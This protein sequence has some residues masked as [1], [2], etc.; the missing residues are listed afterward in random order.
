MSKTFYEIVGNKSYRQLTQ[1]E[2]E[3]VQDRQ[4]ELVI[5]WQDER[6]ELRKAEIFDELFDSLSGLIKGMA[7]RQAE[8]SFSVEQED[9]EGIMNLTLVETLLSFDRS[10][11]KPFQPIFIYNV[12]N[13][14]KMM[15]RQKGY[16]IHD[17]V[18]DRL[19]QP[20]QNDKTTALADILKAESDFA[21]DVETAVV[22]D[23]I[24]DD[25]FGED[26][27]KKTIVHMSVQGFKRNEIVS[28]IA[29]QGKSLDALAKQVNR[30][31]NHFKLNYFNF[32]ESN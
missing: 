26:E 29:E 15:Y 18:N 7:Y 12:R 14:I 17:T 13:E 10:L 1:A 11:E 22:L 27:K 2:K 9:F 8:K 23:E 31:V 4:T 28:A 21:A 6:D 30:T 3:A 5:A 32:I 19:E 24:L 20:N 25:L 16:D